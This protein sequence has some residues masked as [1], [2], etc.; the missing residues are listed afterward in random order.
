[1][2]LP[3]LYPLARRR[4]AVTAFGGYNHTESCG[5]TEF[6]SEE[7]LSARRW[8]ALAPRLPRTLVRTLAK[9]H[10]LYAKN[11]LLWVDGTTLYYNGAAAGTVADS[12]KTFCGIGAKVLIWPDKMYFDLA[13]QTLHPLGAKW[14]ANGTVRFAP[15]R[16]DGTEYD[17][18]AAGASA[19]AAP[20]NGAYWLDTSGETD[21]LR[22]WSSAGEG[23][24]AVAATY[25]KISAAG[26]GTAFA[27]YDTVRLSGVAESAAGAGSAALNTDLILWNKGED[28]IIVTGFLQKAA[29]QTAA[30]G[31]ITLERRIPDLDYLTE[32][33][34]RIW[35]CCSAEHTIYACKLGDPTNWYSYMG[36]AADSYAASVGSDGD[37]TGAATC[38]GYV[39]LFKQNLVHKV[40][41]TKP[42]NF[43]VTTVACPGI[44][45]A[46]GFVTA[47][48]ALY[49]LSPRGVMRYDGSLPE[50]IG[51]KLG[52]SR[53]TA[54]TFGAADGR[55]Y[56]SVKNAAGEWSLLCC[57]TARGL[58]HREDA[59][60]VLGFACEGGSLY[61]LA[62]DGKL[63]AMG[64]E[65]D[66]Y[67]GHAGR[68]AGIAWAGE[69]GEIGLYTADRKFL[70]RLEVR[71]AAAAGAFVRL[72]AQ[73][74][75]AGAWEL[76]GQWSME[77]D[78]TVTAPIVPRRFAS[79]R[80]RISGTGDATVYSVSK[81][82]EQGSEL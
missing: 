5:E 33:D 2:K 47:D 10:G 61:A 26:I 8:P 60:H 80:L 48:T 49:Y 28:W 69:T 23:W 62:A 13:D 81:L 44:D 70:S 31:Q 6:Y 40:Y 65:D 35:G 18:A 1:M 57:D 73:Y 3:P 67:S 38:L 59:L 15:A 58:W 14:A 7:N 51:Q 75:G 66:P 64:R 32:S 76:L 42:A 11:G 27:R 52:A 17:I 25:L 74:D 68:E 4:T 82:L 56:C 19:P 16:E 72:E 63:W 79:M 78:K 41:G 12:D 29:Q 46:G 37:F 39:L 50:G 71:F 21:V 36:T 9:P 34:N 24:S 43:Q 20:A 53:L 54:G 30:D 45:T 22:V 55:L 77:Q